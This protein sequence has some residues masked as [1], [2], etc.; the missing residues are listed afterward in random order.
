MIQAI[1]NELKRINRLLEQ[2]YDVIQYNQDFSEQTINCINKDCLNLK[3]RRE[4]LTVLIYWLKE[5]TR[6]KKSIDKI[7]ENLEEEE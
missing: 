3:N 2:V 1:N 4:Y 5:D 7:I 6:I